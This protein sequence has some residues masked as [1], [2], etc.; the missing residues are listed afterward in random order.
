MLTP[1]ETN[2]DSP[3][4]KT[5]NKIPQRG[6]KMYQIKLKLNN[7]HAALNMNEVI[8]LLLKEVISFEKIISSHAIIQE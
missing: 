4:I 8:P 2:L 6:W 1:T 3:F 7:I 5:E